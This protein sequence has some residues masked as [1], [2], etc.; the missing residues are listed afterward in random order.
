MIVSKFAKNGPAAFQAGKCIARALSTQK[1]YVEITERNGVRTIR[2]SDP[3]TRNS[4]SL[5]MLKCLV[6]EIKRDE[7]NKNLRS[8][9]LT[10]E[11]GKVFSAGHNLKELTATSDKSHKDVFETCSDLMRAI[12]QSPVPVIAAVDGLAAAAGCQLVAAC[13]I[14]VCT[15]RSSFSTPGANVGIFCS[16]PGIPLVRNVPRKNAMYM[17]FTG[18][19]ISGEE[20]YECGLVSKVVADDK[21]DEEI[22]RITDAINMKSRSV[23]HIGKTFLYK[24]M[25]LD[26]ETAY[27]LG[28]E[29]MVNNLKM[30]DA[31]EGIRSFVEKRKPNWS[32]DYEDN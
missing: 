3:S 23:V 13:D 32:H 6:G 19:P 31:Q 17:L 20:A 26:I 8:I 21:L 9:V 2:L 4:L 25:D 28:T 27:L 14:A 10:S 24:Q 5:E 30:K 29:R 7:S 1:K 18:F 11:P 12:S 16:T 22:R 15:E